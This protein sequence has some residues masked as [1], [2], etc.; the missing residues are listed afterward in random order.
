VNLFRGEVN[1]PLTMVSLDGRNGLSLEVTAF[2]SS[3]VWRAVSTWNRSAPTGLLGLGWSLGVDRVVVDDKATGNP[4]DGDYYLQSGGVLD[5]LEW[6]GETNGEL[7]FQCRQHAL[8]QFRYA[9]ATETWTV[10]REDGSVASYG[11][12][13]AEGAVMYGLA[14]GNW[15]GASRRPAGNLRRYAVAWNLAEVRSAWGDRLAWVYDNDEVEVAGG[16]TYTRASYVRQVTDMLDRTVTFRYVPKQRSEYAPPH[17][18]A[19]GEPDPAFQDRY[20]TRALDSLDVRAGEA[21][22]GESGLLYTV[23]LGY[24]LVSVRGQSTDNRGDEFT[25]RFLREVRQERRGRLAAPPVLLEYELEDSAPNV[26]GLASVVFPA[27]GR[28]AFSYGSVTLG[29]Q[30]A[31]AEFKKNITVPSPLPGSRPLVFHGPGYV[32]IAWY[33]DTRAVTVVQVYSFGGRWSQPWTAELP[34]RIRPEFAT[35]AARGNFFALYLS[36]TASAAESVIHLFQQVPGRF[37]D[38]VRHPLRF[39]RLAAEIPE[40][41]VLCAG[42][43]FVVVHSGGDPLVHR[44]S[45]DPLANAWGHAEH[46]RGTSK[47]AV[48]AYRNYYIVAWYDSASGTAPYQIFSRDLTGAWSTGPVGAAGERFEWDPFYAR[49]FWTVAGSFAVAS[50]AASAGT[51]FRLRIV[52]WNENF[53]VAR[54][55]VLPG[56]S[57]GTAV[58][59][60]TIA[61]GPQLLRFDG[62]AWQAFAFGGGAGTPRYAYGDDLGILT[63]VQGSG[64]TSTVAA[65]DADTARW[66]VVT[67]AED[68][69]TEDGDQGTAPDGEGTPALDADQVWAPSIGGSVVTMSDQIFWRDPDGRLRQIGT[70]PVSG[71][72]RS[73]CNRGPSYLAFEDQPANPVTTTTSVLLIENGEISQTVTFPGQRIASDDPIV[74]TAQLAGAAAF[75]TYPGG[76]SIARP[77]E[78]YLH[79]IL[80]QSLADAFDAPVASRVEIDDGYG[81]QVTE[82]AYDAASAVLDPTGQVVQFPRAS[83]IDGPGGAGGRSD[84]S[85]YNGLPEERMPALRSTSRAVLSAAGA[86]YSLLTGLVREAVV[87]DADG[88][89][90]SAS[91]SVWSTLPL[92]QGPASPLGVLLPVSEAKLTRST[93]ITGKL[94]LFDLPASLAADFDAAVIPPQAREAFTAHG[95]PLDPGGQVQV[96]TRGQRWEIVSGANQYQV[97]SNGESLDVLGSSRQDVVNAYDT[98][99][100][101]LAGQETTHTGSS[102]GTEVIQRTLLPAWRVPR[103]EGLAAARMLT[104][105][106]G[107]TVRNVSRK[108]TIGATATTYRDDWPV[109]AP[110]VWAEHEAYTWRGEGTDAPPFDYR[111][112][113]DRPG[114]LRHETFTARGRFGQPTVM[115]NGTG[116][117]VSTLFDAAGQH[118]IAVLANVDL[119]AG[120][121]GSYLGFERYEDDQGWHRPGGEPLADLITD[122]DARTG[123]R[124]LR[125][126]GTADGSPVENEFRLPAS[127]GRLLLACWVKTQP[128][129]PAGESAGWQVGLR[130]DGEAETPQTSSF[131]AIPDTAGEWRRLWAYLTPEAPATGTTVTCRVFNAVDGQPVLVDDVRVAPVE[132]GVAAQVY[133][134]PRFQVSASLD[135]NNNPTF[136]SYDEFQRRIAVA[137]A[138]GRVRELT[139]RAFSRRAGRDRFDPDD[140]NAGLV[141]VPAGP[142]FTEGFPDGSG[143]QDRWQA[144]PPD[145]WQAADGA[146][147]HTA[148]DPGS[149]TLRDSSGFAC[150]GVRLDV[151]RRTGEALAGTAEIRIGRVSTSWEPSGEWLLRDGDTVVDRAAAP[152]FQGA[153]WLLIATEHAVVFF[154]DG[155]QVLRHW[156]PETVTGSLAFTAG[157][158]G[159]GFARVMVFHRP[160]LSVEYFDGTGM[161]RQQQSLGDHGVTVSA[162]LDDQLGRPSLVAKPMI[163]TAQ[164][165]GYQRNFVTGI[166]WRTGQLSGDIASYY[167]GGEQSD[168][169]GYPLYRSRLET[170]ETA[171]VL[172]R[173]EPGAALGI[174][175]A[176]SHTTRLSYGANVRD[177]FL[178]YLPAGRYPEVNLVD[179]DGTA[180]RRYTD[181]AG[182]II[183]IREVPASGGAG[184]RTSFAYDARGALVAV[185]PPNYYAPPDGAE[186]ARYVI[187][188][189]VDGLG[190][191]IAEHSEDTGPTEYIYDQRGLLRFSLTAAGRADESGAPDNVIYQRYDR[192]GR[193]IETGEVR[194]GWDRARLSELAG[195][196]WP[197]DC[198]GWRERRS[199]DGDGSS[200]DAIGRVATVTHHLDSGPAPLKFGFEY[201]ENG[202]VTRFTERRPGEQDWEAEYGYLGTGELARIVYPHPPGTAGATVTYGYNLLGQLTQVGH[203]DAPQAYASY[204]YDAAGGIASEI[205]ALAGPEPLTR[206]YRVNSA[207]WPVSIDS[208]RFSE[209]ISYWENPGYDGA[210]Y[211]NGRVA[212]IDHS[213]PPGPDYSWLIAYD[214]DGRLRVAQC[215][216]A[217]EYS[218]GVGQPIGYDGNGNM[219]TLDDGGTVRTFHYASGTNRLHAVSPPGAGAYGYDRSGRVVQAPDPHRARLE[220]DLVTGLTTAITSKEGTRLDLRYGLG[221]RRLAKELHAADG[222]LLAARRYLFGAGNAPL[223]ERLTGD[224][225]DTEIHYIHGVGGL[226]GLVCGDLRAAVVKDRL[227]SARLLLSERGELLGAYNYRPFGEPMGPASGTRPGLLSYRFTGQEWDEE[228]GLYNYGARL[229]D[230]VTGRFYAPDPAFSPASPYPLAGSDPLNLVDPDGEF[231]FIP[232]LIAMGIGAVVGG[233]GGGLMSGAS[234]SEGRFWAYVG[235]GAGVGALAGAL[236]YGAAAG[237]AAGLTALG[238]A[239]ASTSSAG[240]ILSGVAAGAVGGA[241]DGAVSG[242]LTRLFGNLVDGKSGGAAWD[243]VGSATGWGALTGAAVGGLAG[244]ATGLMIRRSFSG[245]RT[246][247]SGAAQEPHAWALAQRVGGESFD[248]SAGGFGPATQRGGAAAFITHGRR[249]ALLLQVLDP[250]GTVKIQG[251]ADATAAGDFFRG[252]GT[253]RGAFTSMEL[254][255]CN[256]SPAFTQTFATTARTVTRAQSAITTVHS[257]GINTAGGQ[258][259]VP[260]GVWSGQRGVRMLTYYP[261]PRLTAFVRL[262]GY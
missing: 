139:G 86:D 56:R 118:D 178:D 238:Y 161:I 220:A 4:L 154:A 170:A 190:Q 132:G 98:A 93:V 256:P 214:Q 209:R 249:D 5:Q 77:T 213:S 147:W 212:R 175:P 144:E 78:L 135:V 24:E 225:G 72:K 34:G 130:P 151:L 17:E 145:G 252:G 207:G 163:Y 55:Q 19:T 216:L 189:T 184:D 106:A 120:R 61:D 224:G 164:P 109:P 261:N 21:E 29:G 54:D 141:V 107:E 75:V 215:T 111:P 26:G 142:G 186:P 235:I 169:Q 35:I 119:S 183:G 211:Y 10:L 97:A 223:A 40:E 240:F 16:L 69:D 117:A 88:F 150:Y 218:L 18:T 222:E 188:R 73:L 143:W 236:G 247:M 80:D 41:T 167:S 45:Y 89:E 250:D 177:G 32:V 255:A 254:L 11:G 172:E 105:L 100:G 14:W 102:G 234:P 65:Y 44:F 91:H 134:E 62:T 71:A 49:G 226:V 138:T 159:L 113:T 2:Y 90:V 208:E 195:T 125:L 187:T 253:Q 114:W 33:S 166:D 168:D 68:G 162:S 245:P 37:G 3:S 22:D 152:E 158:A 59:G 116:M 84:Y 103:Y 36:D 196:D 136:Y 232:L 194:V 160:R 1:A 204:A 28:T 237:V 229:Y 92:D 221:T 30:D 96:L 227:G 58:V 246:I 198:P 210:R 242:G 157:A 13:D 259:V 25:K 248:L 60:S 182:N 140:P 127:A 129:F 83:K 15:I 67:G 179:P 148:S 20:E 228:S 153:D 27:G 85:F 7:L 66:R 53:S 173:G 203:P 81:T 94:H 131:L 64:T 124:S 128:G 48:A 243:G 197:V 46:G 202:A 230:P 258:V 52:A 121:Q 79:R 95:L 260:T 70:L 171:R 174:G 63:L 6:C 57:L 74:S 39:R 233:I 239:A 231:A 47:V 181:R 51:A 176:A 76:Q 199:W 31:D 82:Y 217:P 99:T 101:Y 241:V 104:A 38:W 205:L 8:W 42:D 244:G 193:L 165:P 219:L 192:L 108:A 137:G 149:V 112:G 9:V 43:R 155:R 185:Y 257:R 50:F 262:F 110:Q 206:R 180:T 146:L 251:A 156:F 133:D 126:P 115:T 200:A 191:L 201:N 123:H 87:R 12:R 23:R 122:G